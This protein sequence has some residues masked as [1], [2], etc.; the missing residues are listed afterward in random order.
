MRFFLMLTIFLSALAPAGADE[1]PFAGP[2]GWSANAN[3]APPP[4][5]AHAVM[6]WHL[7]GD[8]ST[9]VTYVRTTTSYDDSLAAIHTNFTTNKIKP[10]VD[11]DVPCH[12]KTAHVIE[13][14]TGPDG[15]RININRMVVPTSDGVAAITYARSGDTPFDPAVT[16]AETAYCAAAS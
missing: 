13:F 1:A 10:A 12:G 4:D 15:H 5:P 6:Q 3:P 16:Q 8:G 14:A 2:S 9:S 11:K 7:P